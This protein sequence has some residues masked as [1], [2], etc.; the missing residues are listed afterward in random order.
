MIEFKAECGHTVR[1][2]D[3]DAGKVVRCAYCGKEAQV[4]ENEPDDI[5]FFFADLGK[6]V[7]ESKSEPAAGPTGRKRGSVVG[8]H[9]RKKL[10]PFDVITK[11]AYVAAILI[12]VI[13]VGKKYA[14]PLI[15]EQFFGGGREVA[16]SSTDGAIERP[17]P[18]LTPI[19]PPAPPKRYGLLEPRLEQ[20]GRQGLYVNAVPKDINVYYRA[21]DPVADRS[22]PPEG[23]YS[24]ISDPTVKRIAEPSYADELS[25]GVY[26]VVVV[27]PLNDPQLMR[28]FRSYGYGQF[29]QD[30]E[31]S[32]RAK[33]RDERTS[34]YFRPDG[35]QQTRV[36]AMGA[37]INILREYLVTIR[38]SEW[39]VLTPLFIP[40]A[41]GMRDLA[42]RVV[43]ERP[44]S[45]GFDEEYLLDELTYYGVA[46]E[47]RRF[48][49]DV[50][51]RIG[52]ISH[53]EVPEHPDKDRAYPFRMFRIS[54]IDG[55]FTAAHL[56]E[57][58]RVPVELTDGR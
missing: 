9:S 40:V 50:L 39:Q 12:A 28:T 54:P 35:S 18:D 43:R 49:I 26:E 14:W 3:E 51:K 5:D 52:S 45:F 24:W 21:A 58:L 8:S 34:V 25:P 48:I 47:D 36:L 22:K 33:D 23:D 46:N 29:R 30:V 11:M 10:D 44:T 1:A 55:V 27:L 37:R 15:D 42:E 53:H 38:S 19:K 41:C 56:K 13:F 32:A 20:R 6:E 31:M 57:V 7:P 16:G 2:K 17:A 4:P